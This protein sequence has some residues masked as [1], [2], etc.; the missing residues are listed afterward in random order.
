[1]DGAE[2]QY[3]KNVLQQQM[4]KNIVISAG[5]KSSR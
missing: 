4:A 1:V 3:V 2:S 5:Q